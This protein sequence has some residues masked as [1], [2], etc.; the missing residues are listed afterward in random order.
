MLNFIKYIFFLAYDDRTKDADLMVDNILDRKERF[1][2]ITHLYPLAGDKTLVLEDI[3]LINERESPPSSYIGLTQT[4]DKYEKG[5]AKRLICVKLVERQA[6]MKCI[7][8]I[9]FLYRAKRPPQLYTLIGEI[10]GLQMCVKE[11]I[12]P[13]IRRAP[14]PPPSSNLYPNPM[15]N[16][17]YYGSQTSYNSPEN[18]NTNTLTKKSDEKE[19]IDGIPFTINPKY[20]TGNRNSANDL[21]GLDSYRVLSIYEIEQMFNY[22][23]NLERSSI[24]YFNEY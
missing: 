11:G 24:G 9:I 23:F 3:K 18:F 8:D 17:P 1:L 5:T 12:V 7:C 19:V 21:S 22:D 13:P 10:N 4:V 6:G 20:L 15:S 14:L 2:C 16:Q